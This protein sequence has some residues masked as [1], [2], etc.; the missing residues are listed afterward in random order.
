MQEVDKL[1]KKGWPSDPIVCESNGEYQFLLISWDLYH[2][3]V[4][5]YNKLV[6]EFFGVPEDDRKHKEENKDG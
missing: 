2:E 4:R 3:L 6:R 1:L 5:K